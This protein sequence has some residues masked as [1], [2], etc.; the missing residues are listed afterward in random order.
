M[1]DQQL[2]ATVGPDPTKA[3]ESFQGLLAD[4][5]GAVIAA[6]TRAGNLL[7]ESASVFV[8]GFG[9]TLIVIAVLVVRPSSSFCR[10]GFLSVALKFL[11]T[12]SARMEVGDGC[13]QADRGVGRGSGGA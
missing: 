11:L 2:P 7:K 4:P 6:T 5:L 8:G 10:V 12:S 9:A 13:H 3:P 1:G